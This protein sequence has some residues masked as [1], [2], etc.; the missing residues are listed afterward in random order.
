MSYFRGAA[1]DADDL[2]V[3]TH[4]LRT[5]TT[6]ARFLKWWEG[7]FIAGVGSFNLE[8]SL[9]LTIRL[10][11]AEGL[12]SVSQKGRVALLDKGKHFAEVLK[13]YPDIFSEEKE[14]LLR[15]V[16]ISTAKLKRAIALIR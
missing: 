11:R 13:L 12:V 1:A 14:F 3:V 6:R 2:N 9:D 15:L 5:P 7:E 10:A 8:P 4:A 16:P